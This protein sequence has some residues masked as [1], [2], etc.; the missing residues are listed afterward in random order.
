VLRKAEYFNKHSQF[1][2]AESKHIMT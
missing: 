2:E 1:I